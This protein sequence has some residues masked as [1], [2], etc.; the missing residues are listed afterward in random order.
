M[1][2]SDLNQVCALASQH[3]DLEVQLAELD[4]RNV[5]VGVYSKAFNTCA[6]PGMR[7]YDDAQMTAAVR[8]GVRSE[9][10]RRLA[11]IEGQLQALAVDLA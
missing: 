5:Q 1:K 2:L 8:D 4:L 9:L 6:G 10:K 7:V 11:D 3:K